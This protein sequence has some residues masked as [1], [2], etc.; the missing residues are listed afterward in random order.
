[1]DMK[2]KEPTVTPSD[3]VDVE[4]TNLEANLSKQSLVQKGFFD[5]FFLRHF[6]LER[7]RRQNGGAK[8]LAARSPSVNA[9]YFARYLAMQVRLETRAR[10]L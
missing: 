8:E 6:F 4:K 5:D 2:D 1:M 10:A 7:R 3:N 9:G